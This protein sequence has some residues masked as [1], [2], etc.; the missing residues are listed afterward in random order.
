[1]F[2]A[3]RFNL[4]KNVQFKNIFI[5]VKQGIKRLILG[6]GSHFSFHCKMG[7]ESLNLFLPHVLW[8][9]LIMKK[10]E[11]LYPT[12][13]GLFSSDRI[14]PEPDFLPN[15]IQEFHWFRIHNSP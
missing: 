9:F 8:M 2:G 14:M 11:P 1:L 15:L 7:K 6:R 4:C 13:V 10:N 12:D 5:K 3:I